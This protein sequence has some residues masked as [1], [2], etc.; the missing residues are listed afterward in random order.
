MGDGSREKGFAMDWV[1]SASRN[2]PMRGYLS[3]SYLGSRTKAVIDKDA[4]VILVNEK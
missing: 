2:N 4:S 1:L 3:K